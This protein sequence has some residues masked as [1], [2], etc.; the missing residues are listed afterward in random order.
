[1]LESPRLPVSLGS[2]FPIVARRLGLASVVSAVG[3]RRDLAVGID[4]GPGRVDG[5]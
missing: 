3:W 2:L 5:W 4:D 1:M